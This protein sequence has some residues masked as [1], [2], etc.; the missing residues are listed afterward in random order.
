MWLMPRQDEPRDFVIATGVTH[1]VEE[2]CEAACGVL[3]LD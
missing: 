3:D 1:S 2:F